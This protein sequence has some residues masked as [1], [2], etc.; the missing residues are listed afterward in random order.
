M[1]VA[2]AALL[3]CLV[4]AAVFSSQSHGPGGRATTGQGVQAHP[5]VG[6]S[7][8]DLSQLG[9]RIDSDLDQIAADQQA[10]AT[11]NSQQDQVQP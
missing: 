6:S 4:G 9:A 5:T 11:D 7:L 1:P 2:A 10:A 3:V 8:A